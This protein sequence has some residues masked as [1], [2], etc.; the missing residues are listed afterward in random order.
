MRS[1]RSSDDFSADLRGGVLTIGNFDGLHIGHQAL[2]RAVVERGRELGVATGV[3][4]FDPHPQRVLHPDQ[5]LPRLSTWEQIEFALRAGEVDFLV[6]EPFTSTFSALTPEVF[7]SEIIRDRL[8]PR[9]IL[10]G[11]DFHF[12]KGARGSGQTL[13]RIGPTLGIRVTVIPQVRAGSRDVSSTRIRQ[14]LRDGAVEEAAL[15]LG[16]PYALW[17]TVV[18]GERRGR[19]L[20]F[21]TANLES[22]NELIPRSGVYATTVRLFQGEEPRGDALPSVTNVGTRPTFEPGEI[23]AEAH[24]FDFDGDLYGRRIELRFHARIRDER[25]FPGPAELAAQIRR[26]SERARELLAS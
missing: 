9:E 19:T 1:Y 7:L 21:P 22:E 18:L 24:L 12:G 13:M 3:Y 4:T 20:G 16:R 15:C 11:R 8:A 17:G 23:L 10:V 6:R 14:L 25:R 26:D 2:L 5:P